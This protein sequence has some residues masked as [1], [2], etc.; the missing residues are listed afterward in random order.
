MKPDQKPVY[1]S[2][3][4]QLGKL[5]ESQKPLSKEFGHESHDE[6][7][8]IVVHQVYELW[9]K[10]ILHEMNSIIDIFSQN[11]IPEN[12][13]STVEARLGRILKIQGLLID[14]MPVM[15][16]MTPMDFLEFRDLLIPASGFQSVQFKEIEAKM[17]LNSDWRFAVDKDAFLGRLSAGDRAAVENVEKQA[18]IFDRVQAWLER[19]PFTEAKDVD[20]DFWAQYKANVD[21][22]LE[23]DAQVIANSTFM[24]P[25]EKEIQNQFLAGT[26]ETFASLFDEKKYYELVVR[27]ERRLSQKAMVN[28]LFIFLFRDEP[29]L[30]M[31]FK[32]LNS[33][34][35]LDENFT[36]WRHRHAMMAHRMLGTK[37]GTGGSSGHHYLKMAAD[38]NRVYLDLFNISTFLIPRNELP[39]LPQALR[40]SMNF[41]FAE[42]K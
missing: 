8:F 21:T 5:L 29:A 39:E 17:G 16:T 23:R 36:T 31:P 9:F 40:K 3:Y 7:L 10:Q 13:L 35:E 27:G 33:L 37:I 12:K 20:F 30:F 19:M 11:F 6:T 2:E 22:M 38:K 4:L 34:I 1:Y 15:E 32:I 42:S 25:K 24:G 14:Q 26:R 28:A 18:S 41:Y